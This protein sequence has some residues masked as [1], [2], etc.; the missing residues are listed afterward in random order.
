[1]SPRPP[2]PEIVEDGV[3]GLVVEESARGLEQG[4]E[5]LLADAPLRERL[6]AGA[7]EAARRRFDLVR[8]AT[9]VTGFYGR[10]L[11]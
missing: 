2:L 7:R 3:A 8:Q 1:V 10:V 6:R 11:A 4:L 5:R 9:A